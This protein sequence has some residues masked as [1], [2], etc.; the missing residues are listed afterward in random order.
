MEAYITLV[1]SLNRGAYLP[2]QLANELPLCI[3]ATSV[4]ISLPMT[5]AESACIPRFASYLVMM[6]CIICN[7]I[8]LPRMYLLNASHCTTIVLA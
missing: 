5:H 4:D 2:T 3:S 8:L 7:G 1:P 6:P